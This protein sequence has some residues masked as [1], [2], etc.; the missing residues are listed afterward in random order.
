MQ[1]KM[2]PIEKDNSFCLGGP[3]HDTLGKHS[4]T[5]GAL[6]LIGVC[7]AIYQIIVLHVKDEY[8]KISTGHSTFPTM[9]KEGQRIQLFYAWLVRRL[10]ALDLG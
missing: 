4:D 7:I 5:S 9:G 8:L 3:F 2:K 1:Q 10:E 6:W